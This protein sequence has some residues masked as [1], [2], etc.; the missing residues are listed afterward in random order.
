MVIRSVTVL[1]SVSGSLPIGLVSRTL[2]FRR[3]GLGGRGVSR[4]AV[5]SGRWRVSVLRP[6]F[7]VRLTDRVSSG[8]AIISMV[9]VCSPG[10]ST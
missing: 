9:T 6:P 10:P 2:V 5:V 7:M 4:P 3:G 1:T 8:E